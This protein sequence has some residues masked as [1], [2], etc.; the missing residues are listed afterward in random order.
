MTFK[1]WVEILNALLTPLIAVIALFIAWQQYR[2]NHNSLRNQ[3]YERRHAVFKAF[4][5]YLADVMREGKT[6]YQRTGQFYAEASEAEFLF[7]KAISKHM[8]ELYSKGIELVS[9][10]E[11]MYPS[12]G[13]PGLPVG[14]E[15]SKVAKDKG[16]LIKWFTR[17]IKITKEILKAEMKVG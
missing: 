15:R 12:D 17:Q 3:L 6:N 16:E 10:H 7:S 4:M 8:E 1:E 9:L 2:V 14:E 5:S 13:S 11:Q